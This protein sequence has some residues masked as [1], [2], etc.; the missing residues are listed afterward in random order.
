MEM[1]RNAMEIFILLDRS[2]CRKCGEKTCMAFAGAVL[3]GQKKLEH[4]PKIDAATLA[5]YSMVQGQSTAVDDDPEAS[6]V[7]LRQQVREI[8]L[9]ETARRV[10]GE[11]VNGRLIVRILGKDFSVDTEGNL[12]SFIHIIPWVSAPF[13]TYVLHC[14]GTPV[15]GEWISFREIKGGRERYPLFQKR[16]E[17]AMKRV[18]DTWPDLF[19][20]IVS[21]FNGRRVEAHFDSD[22]S[23]VLPVLPLVPLLI[24][25]WR[26]ADGIDSS[27]NIFFDQSIN[28]NLDVGAAYMLATGLTQMFEKLALRHGYTIPQ[29]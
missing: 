16:G 5:R 17:E 11:F 10:G 15:T 13:L 1:F 18:A 12:S 24:C 26:E 4:C 21:L 23:V 25:Y 7:V 19:S 9:T 14:Q 29:K 8:D 28:A 22:I 3:R 27:L 20:D 6:L 2:N